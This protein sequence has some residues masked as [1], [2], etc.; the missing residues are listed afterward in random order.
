MQSYCAIRTPELCGIALKGWEEMEV[1]SEKVWISTPTYHEEEIDYIKEAILTNWKSTIGEN[2]DEIERLVCEKI[3][4]RYA[5]A[6]SS[7]TSALHLAVI[8]A[9]V[10]KGDYVLCSDMTFCA[11]IN[12][13]IYENATPVLIDSEYDSWNMDPVA[14]EKAFKLYPN[15]K[16]VICA[17]LYGTPSKLDEIRDICD[18]YGAVLIEDAA[19]SFGASYRGK[20][21]GTFGH[22][23][24]IS[25]NGNKIITGS[26]GG[27]LLTDDEKIAEHIRKLSTQSKEPVP[28]YQHEEIGYN[29]RMSNIVAGIIRGQLPYL[30]DHIAQKK[31]IYERYREGLTGLPLTLNPHTPDSEPNFWLSC[32]LIN[33]DA[34]CEQKR[35]DMTVT[36]ERESGKSCPTEIFETLK[37]M[38]V[39]SRPIW[40]PLHMQPVYKDCPS[41]SV[42]DSFSVCEDIFERGLCLP[43]DNKMKAETQDIII[44][45]IRSCFE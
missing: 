5:V 12:P 37:A 39:E 35:T 36:F 7:G 3:G 17:N 6:L 9:G 45:T 10:G 2:I 24:V 28:W 22:L 8:E 30:E 11:T 31:A 21:S 18:R 44:Q 27:C 26:T 16:A 20:M 14:L 25:F 33:K 38:N 32:I 13:V 1:F 4:C 40:K 29:Y 19:E 15:A 43:S 23:N 34:M 41:V 42:D